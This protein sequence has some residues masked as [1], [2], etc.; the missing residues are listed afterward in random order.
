MYTEIT[1]GDR[2]REKREELK[3]TQAELAEYM[4]YKSR[5]SINKIEKGT[6]DIPQ[7][8]VVRFAEALNTTVSYLMG[9]DDDG[10]LIASL[11]QEILKHFDGDVEKALEFEKVQAKD[12]MMEP[13]HSSIQKIEQ[14]LKDFIT[15]DTTNS[16]DK[17]IPIYKG[18]E[19]TGNTYR[20]KE[21][22]G[23]TYFGKLED[24]EHH[25]CLEIPNNDFEPEFLQGDTALIHRQV[26]LENEKYF[27]IVIG[28]TPTIRKVTIKD[29]QTV[30]LKADNPNTQLIFE[31][32]DNL[33]IVGKVVSLK[34]TRDKKL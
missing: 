25:I 20:F 29:S 31:N 18:V 32:K 26:E 3:M 24:F 23:Y 28:E 21:R 8:K 27:Y 7:S 1:I 4:G 2:I 12:G 5:S 11:N 17:P 34:K 33:K 14:Q 6:N 9:W 22:S 13:A 10:A 19:F 16:W 15:S 30:I